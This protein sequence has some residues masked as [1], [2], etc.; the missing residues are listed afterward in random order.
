M[1]PVD[2]LIK[3][4]VD[5][6]NKSKAIIAIERDKLRDLHSDLETFIDDLDM[7][8]EQL[9]SGCREIESG[10]DTISGSV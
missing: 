1:K 7:G 10:L 5:K 6:I 8:I 4:T 2:K 9:E 3:D